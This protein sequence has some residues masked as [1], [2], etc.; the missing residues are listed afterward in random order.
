MDSGGVRVSLGSNI[1]ALE[2]RIKSPKALRI[3]FVELA[4]AQK[5]A[6]L[7]LAPLL[8]G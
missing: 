8:S 5:N 2:T 6:G 4:N 3:M 7:P 1:N